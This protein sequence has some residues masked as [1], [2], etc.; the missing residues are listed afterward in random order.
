MLHRA[1]SLLT[2]LSFC[3]VLSAS[4][5]AED[6]PNPWE[7]HAVKG[8]VCRDGSEAGY[9][10]KRRVFDERVVMLLG[11]GGAC[12]NVLTC[13]LNPRSV[14]N[15]FPK[16]LGIFAQRDDN[17]VRDWNQ[18]YVPYC[19]GDNFGGNR[20]DVFI[21][22]M[23]KKQNF[24]GHKNLK[25]ILDDV[26]ATLPTMEHLVFG[27][28]SAGGFGSI[29]NYV[30]VRKRFPQVPVT[31]LDDSGVP[32]EDEFIAPCLQKRFRTTWGL[33][34]SFPE[35]CEDCRPANGGGMV[36]LVRHIREEYGD[37][38]QGA[39]MSKEDNVLRFF[40]GYS[41]NSC[42]TLLPGMP[43]QEYA[44]GLESLRQNYFQG[45]MKTFIIPG[46]QHTFINSASFY[47][48]TVDGQT[49]ASWVGDLIANRA[50]SRY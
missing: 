45:S 25:L 22:G 4:L 5:Y 18:I 20:S 12:F 44:R 28:M 41:K 15:Q 31:L 6:T 36:N 29:L 16:D 7:W 50:E 48:M 46:S 19:S 47:T 42:N 35:E 11:P 9:F 26:A 24:L 39:I 3:M 1:R 32:L 30:D 10:L 38:Q 14:G 33:N 2:F 34:E 23:L 40:F 17:P 13:E 21:L 43:A 8:T 49:L 37:F 27:G